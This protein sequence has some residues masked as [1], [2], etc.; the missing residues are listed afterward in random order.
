MTIAIINLIFLLFYIF[1]D[2]ARLYVWKQ[3]ENKYILIF[4]TIID[5]ITLIV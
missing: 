5:L 2:A 3:K 1:E 4:E